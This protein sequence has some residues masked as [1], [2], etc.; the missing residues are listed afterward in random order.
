MKNIVLELSS[1]SCKDA[2]KEIQ[3]YQ[4]Q[5]K[6]KLDE[7]CRRIAQIGATEAQAH[8]SRMYGNTDATVLEPIKIDNGYKLV[9]QGTDV[10]FIEFGTGDQVS[11]H[12][13][14]S[15]PV[16]YGTWS[17]EHQ[18]QLTRYGFWWYGGEKLTG[19][20]AEMPMYYAGKRMREEIPRVIKEV[21]SQ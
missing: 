21:F 16:G 15:V 13:V 2:I 3:Q 12:A 11:P 6:P 1:E 8:L 5:I 20:P 17:A 4:K 19:T 7:V 14:T 10:Y 9:L 18:Q